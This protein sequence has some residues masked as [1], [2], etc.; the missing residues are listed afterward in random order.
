MPRMREKDDVAL[1][2]LYIMLAVDMGAFMNI[3]H[4]RKTMTQMNQKFGGKKINK[5]F[6]EYHELFRLN[7]D[8]E[9]SG[10]AWGSINMIHPDTTDEEHNCDPDADGKWKA[11]EK[12]NGLIKWEWITDPKHPDFDPKNGLV[13]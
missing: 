2:L 4:V 12:N 8:F 3:P 10:L 11:T 6:A 9:L 1:K 7:G 13:E 5:K